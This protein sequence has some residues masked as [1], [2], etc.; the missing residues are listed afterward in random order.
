MKEDLLNKLN[1]QPDPPCVKF[2]CEHR[3]A[4][5]AQELACSA[6]AHY[7]QTGEVKHPYFDFPQRSTAVQRPIWRDRAYPSRRIFELIDAD[8]WNTNTMPDK[9]LDDL[10]D[11]ALD[12]RSGRRSVD[13]WLAVGMDRA[14]RTLRRANGR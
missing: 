9:P 1:S 8:D 2:A 14:Q 13:H 4:C 12:E 11:D 3:D 5:A 10:V 6:F 7:Y